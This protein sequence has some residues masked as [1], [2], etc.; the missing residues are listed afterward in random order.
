[1]SDLSPRSRQVLIQGDRALGPSAPVR[2]RIRAGVAA[3]LAAAET[4]AAAGPSPTGAPAEPA[5]GAA[6][7]RLGAVASPGATAAIIK[8][9]LCTLLTAVVAGGALWLR[10]RTANAPPRVPARSASA[11]APAAAGTEP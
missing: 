5:P 3:R 4:G 6:A 1:M 10:G 8:L 9:T 11:P 7:T 2:A